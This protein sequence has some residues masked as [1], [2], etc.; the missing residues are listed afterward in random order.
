MLRNR[1]RIAFARVVLFSL[2]LCFGALPAA[3]GQ[4]TAGQILGSIAFKQDDTGSVYGFQIQNLSDVLPDSMPANVIF[5]NLSVTTNLSATPASLDAAFGAPVRIGPGTAFDTTNSAYNLPIDNAFLYDATNP[6]TVTPTS[7]LLKGT[8]LDSTG[9]SLNL[10]FSAQ[11]NAADL[12][13]PGLGEIGNPVNIIVASAPAP[14]VGTP[15]SMALVLTAGL[16]F[17]RR[18]RQTLCRSGG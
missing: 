3:F 17:R 10:S 18:Q 9:K 5:A 11:M 8:L 14:E 2:A 12:A 13:P 16:L 4:L 7:V 1:L 6:S 15:V